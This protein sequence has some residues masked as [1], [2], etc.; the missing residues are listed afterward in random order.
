MNGQN[1]LFLDSPSIRQETDAPTRLGFLK[2]NVK[3][4]TL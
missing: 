3:K 4:E 2:I 1:I